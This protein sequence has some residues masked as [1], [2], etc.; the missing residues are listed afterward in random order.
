MASP[1]ID[2]RGLMKPKRNDK[3]QAGEEP[4]ACGYN[5]VALRQSFLKK[6]MLGQLSHL[7]EVVAV[8]FGGLD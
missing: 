7:Y 2:Y 4:E 5:I 3:C 1:T 6:T 8:V